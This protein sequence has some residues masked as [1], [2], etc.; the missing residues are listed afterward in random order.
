VG[1]CDGQ[2]DRIIL[3]V[4]LNRVDPKVLTG[5]NRALF[6]GHE[7]GVGE[8]PTLMLGINCHID[9]TTTTR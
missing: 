9:I 4:E 1:F 3:V 8:R 2:V 7:Y 6:T 5:C